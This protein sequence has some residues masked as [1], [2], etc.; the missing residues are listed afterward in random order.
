[1]NK[2]AQL[3]K[4]ADVTWDMADEHLEQSAAG[5]KVGDL[6]WQPKMG[7]GHI[8]VSE[9]K[10]NG[11]AFYCGYCGG[12]MSSTSGYCEGVYP[13]CECGRVDI[14]D[15]HVFILARPR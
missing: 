11:G 15:H 4:C 10:C 3:F 9:A 1:M 6:V 13:Q 5:A 14:C 2:T 7:V 12:M 8:L